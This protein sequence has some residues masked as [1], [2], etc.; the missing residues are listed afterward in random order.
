M[1]VKL[2]KKLLYEAERHVKQLKDSGAWHGMPPKIEACKT[3]NTADCNDAID[4][5]AR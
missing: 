2:T 4:G 5:G 1:S 3:H